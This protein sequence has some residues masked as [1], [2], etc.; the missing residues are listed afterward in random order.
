MAE[1][2]LMYIFHQLKSINSPLALQFQKSLK[3]RID[4]RRNKDLVSVLMFLHHGVYPKAN[5]FFTY[6]SKATIKTTA[7]SL[8]KRLFPSD[9]PDMD[10]S[11]DDP[12]VVEDDN[13]YTKLQRCIASF[14]KTQAAATIGQHLSIEVVGSK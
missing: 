14:T 9:I 11:D 8:M 4:Q 3:N 2:T 6:S 5:E 1:A 10:N 7:T 13:E 12:E